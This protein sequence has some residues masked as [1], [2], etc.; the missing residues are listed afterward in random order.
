MDRVPQRD[1]TIHESS[2]KWQRK[3]AEVRKETDKFR[4]LRE[5][6]DELQRSFHPGLSAK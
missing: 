3:Q 5:L 6:K 2:H 1:D 4:Q